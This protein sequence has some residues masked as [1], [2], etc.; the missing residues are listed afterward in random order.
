MSKRVESVH[1]KRESLCPPDRPRRWSNFL[2]R[3][4]FF[5]FAR[6]P[7]LCFPVRA[8]ARLDNTDIGA[9]HGLDRDHRAPGQLPLCTNYSSGG[10]DQ[11]DQMARLF[12]LI[13]LLTTVQF[14]PKLIK[15]IATA[16][17]MFLPKPS[18]VCLW[19]LKVCPSVEISP[20]MVTL[21]MTY[22]PRCM[23]FPMQTHPYLIPP[24]P[25]PILVPF[26]SYFL[27]HVSSN[28]ILKRRTSLWRLFL[29][30]FARNILYQFNSFFIFTSSRL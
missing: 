10:G 26:I 18:K 20:N 25:S 30:S 15:K 19:F 24:P 28:E 12:F 21:V 3:T 27:F 29:S 11:C 1:Q 22:L 13:W 17:S 9:Q 5:F 14:S 6:F 4:F 23:Y 8:C 2:G 7:S 16:S